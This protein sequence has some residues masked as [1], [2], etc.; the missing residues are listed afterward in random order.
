[1][2]RSDVITL[3]KKTPVQDDYG[4]WTTTKTK[5]DVFV[6]VDSISQ[7][8]FFEA[9]RN[10]LNPEFRFRMFNGDYDGETAC[11]FH[12]DSY[13]VYRTYLRR[14]DVLELYVERKGGTNK[15]ASGGSE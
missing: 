14:N 4:R 11:E 3:I 8:E 1:M 10:G 5:R 15:A 7:A 2:D 13:A 6:Q 9:G 12:G